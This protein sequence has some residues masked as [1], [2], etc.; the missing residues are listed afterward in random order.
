MYQ[1]QMKIVIQKIKEKETHQDKMNVYFD[2]LQNKRAQS[3]NELMLAERPTREDI[4]EEINGAKKK[5]IL[6]NKKEKDPL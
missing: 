5:Q 6:E 3:L 1:E 2:W 4:F